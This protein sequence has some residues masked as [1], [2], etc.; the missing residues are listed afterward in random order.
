MPRARSPLTH[1]NR[2][3]PTTARRAPGLASVSCRAGA[4]RIAWPRRKLA[5]EVT[6]AVIRLTAVKTRTLA[7]ST[8]G[9]RGSAARVA[10]IVPLAYS[11]L[12]TRMPRMPMTRAPPRYAPTR[13]TSVGSNA[14]R[15]AADSVVQC[16]R[17]TP[18]AMALTATPVKTVRPSVHI[19][20]RTVRSLVHSDPSSPFIETRPAG[21][22]GT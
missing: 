7:A 20:E 17:V 11:P 18:M 1:R 4:V 10:R 8:S 19:V 12:I 6:S 9:R 5:N 22:A 3:T 21:S 15:A 14:D 2:P 16:A 13:L